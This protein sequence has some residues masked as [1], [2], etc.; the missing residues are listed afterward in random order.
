MGEVKTRQKTCIFT[1]DL[2]GGVSCFCAKYASFQFL[3]TFYGW[4]LHVF[5]RSIR[6]F[7]F[8]RFLPTFYG[9]GFVNAFFDPKRI[10]VRFALILPSIC[11]QFAL[12]LPPNLPS[13]SGAEHFVTFCPFFRLF[14]VYPGRFARN[15]RPFWRPLF[16]H[17]RALNMLIAFCHFRRASECASW[18]GPPGLTKSVASVGEK[19]SH[20]SA[21]TCCNFWAPQCASS[22]FWAPQYACVAAEPSIRNGGSTD[23]CSLR[24]QRRT[25]LGRRR[26]LVILTEQ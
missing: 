22:N 25:P 6:V 18:N 21:I 24:R 23:C 1:T 26:N 9:W 11:P 17:V 2:W 4:G 7:N 12:D 10:W 3:P 8:D 13:H 5:A 14:R 16:P 15:L 19:A 20:P